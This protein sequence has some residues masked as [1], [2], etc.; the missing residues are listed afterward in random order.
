MEESL[1]N[2][3]LERSSFILIGLTGRTGSG[4]TTAARI[5]ESSSLDCPS[6]EDLQHDGEQFY[7]GL[8][9]ARYRNVSH[10]AEANWEHFYSIS[11]S[12]LISAYFLN[13]DIS[14]ATDFVYENRLTDLELEAVEKVLSEGIF[15]KASIK[16]SYKTLLSKLL[17]HSRKLDLTESELS[18]FRNFLKAFRVFNSKLKDELNNLQSGLYVSVFQAAGNSIRRRGKITPG[19]TSEP[20]D[21]Q[22][23][24]SL[25]E[26]MNRVVKAIRKASKDGKAFIV[27]DAIRNPF[28]A[29][30]F[31][32]RYAAFYL[33]SINA[34][35]EDR[36]KYLQNYRKF[37]KQQLIEL[38]DKESGKVQDEQD[39]KEYQLISQN[40]KR[41]V[42]ISD[43]HI[44][45]PRNELH[46]N[47][48]LKAQLAW[49]YALML[50]PGLTTPRSHERVMQLAYTAKTNSG[51]IS[52]QVG[53]A[54]TD[55]DFS[56]KAIGWNDVAKGQVP[57]SLRS[58]DGLKNSFDDVVY[59]HFERNDEKFRGKADEKLIPLQELGNQLKGRNLAY[60]FKDIKNSV[61]K[62][63]NQVHTR[64]LHAE[65]NAFLQLSKYGSAG[66]QGGK[67]FTTAS[68]CE[69]C[70]KKAYQLD[71]KDIYFIDPY[72]GIAR[73]HILNIG[74][75]PPNLIQFMGAIGRG[76]HQL[77]E[78][79]L[80]YKDE[81]SFFT[82]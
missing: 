19:F 75:N 52:R 45:N 63:G 25:P 57:C 37:T 18:R 2:L 23:V 58:L 32:E 8:D 7:K 51:C 81:L 13:L 26:S 41:C 11:V 14:T 46:N 71:I 3:F 47:N 21:P 82:E 59:S 69:L 67:L 44:F 79:S 43:I 70:A 9:V 61:D 66:I 29:R 62:K 17:D 16:K 76:Y 48:I 36:A 74:S 68:P 80:S 20:F 15:S 35:E 27:L 65:E 30:Y 72:P 42:E 54:I 22:S 50:H 10:Y 39:E 31:K 64:S 28:E 6:I 78:P 12:D 49:Y 60:C 24:F 38:D 73:D 77:Y 4:C 1:S 33:V 40:V 56:V 55:Q 34:P 53:A 5:L